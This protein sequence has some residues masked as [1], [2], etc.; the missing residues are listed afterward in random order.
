VTPA[1]AAPAPSSILS[2][3]NLIS[4]FKFIAVAAIIFFGVGEWQGWYVGLATQTPVLVYKKD[5]THTHTRQTTHAESYEFTLSGRLRQGN[6]I[7]EASY[8]RPPSVQ[9][10][11]QGEPERRVFRQEFRAGEPIVL[12]ENLRNGAGIYRIR[13]IFDDA[14]GSLRLKVPGNALL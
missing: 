11:R 5:Y 14:T 6:L 8:E 1:P 3:V 9:T 10:S 13:L 2:N 12:S 7:V 4:L